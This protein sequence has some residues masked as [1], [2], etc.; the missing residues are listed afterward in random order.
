LKCHEIT[1]PVKPSVQSVEIVVVCC[2]HI[3]HKAF[4][5]KRAKK[6][7]D[8][9]LA[10]PNR[11]AVNLGDD[12]ENAVPGDEEHN[13]MMWDSNM[14]PEEQYRKA[15]E[16]WEP[17]ASAKKLLITHDSNHAWR[18]EAKTGISIAKN[19]NVFLQGLTTK[20][21]TTDPQ[22]DASPRWGHWQALTKLNIGKQVYLV[23]SWHGVG[24]GCTPEASLRKCRSMAVTHRADLFV[25]GHSHQRIAWSDNYMV[26]AG[27]G[28]EAQERQR[29]FAVTGGYLGWHGTY[30][31]RKGL[32]P[33][34][35]GSVVVKLGVKEWDIKTSI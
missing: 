34:R 32:P 3:G 20:H 7:R 25:M 27:N 16:F 23:H 1:I 31:E 12:M 5:Y 14:H 18:S 17:V 10:D 8:W 24:S 4:D 13:S 33:N 28:L 2:L 9:I 11:Y 29:M 26:H 35:R 22:P 15:A 30:A 21:K 19:L 6:W